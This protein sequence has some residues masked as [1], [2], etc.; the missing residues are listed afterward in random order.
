MSETLKI[1]DAH[2]H[3]WDLGANYYPWLHDEPNAGFFL[4]D[5]EA[6]KRDYLPPDYRSDADGLEVVKTVHC[7]AEWDRNNQ[8]GETRWLTEVAARYGMPNAIVAHAW[9]HTENSYAVLE[10]QSQFSMVRGIRSKPVTSAKPEAKVSGQPGAMDD[11]RWREGFAALREFGFSWDLRVPHWHL[12]EAA[13]VVAE[14]P[15]I[16]VVLNHTGF[17]WDRSPA[18]LA[19][20]RDGMRV[21]AECEHVWLKVSE[22]GLKDQP[23]DAESN[24][25]V[26]R[27]AVEIF[28]IHRCMFASNFPVSGLRVGYPQLVADMRAY[29]SDLSV[30]EM[31]GFFHDNACEFYRI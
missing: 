30:A 18:G 13:E 28:G 24:R 20:W 19:A 9:F 6:L 31:Q 15:D 10:A 23:W 4:G 21:L 7:E 27:E 1:V 14:H 17:P 12:T 5:Y 11:P 22:L 8:V 26:V 25:I 2:H 3:L 29:L 16:P